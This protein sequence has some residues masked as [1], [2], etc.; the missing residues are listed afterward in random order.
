MKKVYEHTLPTPRHQIRTDYHEE[1]DSYVLKPGE[2]LDVGGVITGELIDDIGHLYI[3]A[4]ANIR[5]RTI[6]ERQGEINARNQKN[7]AKQNTRRINRK[8]FKLCLYL[9]QQHNPAV[10]EQEFKSFLASL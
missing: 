4:G 3:Q 9:Y 1:P 7:T 10:N 6:P 2:T 8:L 5:L